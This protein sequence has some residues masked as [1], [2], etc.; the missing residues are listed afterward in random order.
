MSVKFYSRPGCP[1]CGATRK[2]LEAHEVEFSE[3][4]VD[5]DPWARLEAVEFGYREVPVVVTDR[6]SWSG[7]RPDLIDAIG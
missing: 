3:Y 5:V 1:Q 6:G 7:Y 4:D 2:R